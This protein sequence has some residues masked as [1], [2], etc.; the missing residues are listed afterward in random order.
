M[1]EEGDKFKVIGD[2]TMRGKTMEVT[3]DA[4][5]Q[6]TGTD[7]WGGTRAGFSAT[8]TIDRRDWGLQW[9]QALETGGVLVGNNVKLEIEA[10]AVK[11]TGEAKAAA[12]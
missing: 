2:L 4:V 12:D 5:F 9:N 6:G 11:Q 1:K 10:Q 8:A 7:P 3:L